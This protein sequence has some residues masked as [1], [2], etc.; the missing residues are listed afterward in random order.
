[1]YVGA[2]TCPPDVDQ[3][4]IGV[5]D[6]NRR[7]RGL[8]FALWQ[9]AEPLVMMWGVALTPD[10]LLIHEVLNSNTPRTKPE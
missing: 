3:A 8:T 5:F 9:T 2:L 4:N 6:L 1:M 10:F 7:L